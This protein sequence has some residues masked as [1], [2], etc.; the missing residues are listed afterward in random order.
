[1][2]VRQKLESLVGHRGRSV[3]RVGSW[4][5]VAKACAAANL[6][7]TIPFVVAALDSTGFGAWATLLS[8]VIFAGF[9]DFGVGNGTMNLIAAAQAR[10]ALEEVALL[11]GEART[12]LMKIGISLALLLVPLI[13]WLPWEQLLGLPQDLAA[14]GRIASGI[15]LAAITLSVPLNLAYRIQLALGRGETGFKWQAAGQIATLLA[16]VICSLTWASLP[17]LTAA[18]VLTPLVAALA[19]TLNLHK[20]SWLR[21][22]AR[23]SQIEAPNARRRIRDESLLFL[24]LQLSAALA[25][26]ADLLL[27][28][29]LRSADE[30]GHYAVVQR[31][32][33]VI[34]LALSL[35]WA[36]LWPTYRKA[37]AAG[38]HAWVA[39]TLRRSVVLGGLF[40]AVSSTVIV[41][42]FGIV[43]TQLLGGMS[44]G[45]ILLSGFATWS[46]VEAG[47]T[48]MATFLNSASILRFQ[49]AF[50]TLF[51]LIC[52][53]AK[54]WALVNLDSNWIPWITVGTYLL[55][56][57]IPMAICWPRIWSQA[58]SHRY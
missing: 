38:E 55:A 34:P 41:L 1:M 42:A 26:S 36:P 40:A 8:L 29:S 46:I 45:L 58:T 37:L 16:V 12:L 27:I 39:S 54:A 56:S 3:I 7:L 10:G 14:D 25:F 4:S 21:S 28:S 19:C 50:S 48:A 17:A 35:A 18:A 31:V 33:S 23:S 57:V 11:Y 52:I 20:I 30:A 5:F 53:S 43:E 32:F 9:M 13:V 24:V 51:A 15:V 2:A 22:T 47:G 49:I 6:F 44:V